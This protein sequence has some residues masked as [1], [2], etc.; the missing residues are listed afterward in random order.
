[1]LFC[2]RSLFCYASLCVH[3]SFG[4]ISP[5]CFTFFVF[6]VSFGCYH[7]MPLPH[8]AVGWSAVSDCGIS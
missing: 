6:L 7:S 4:I 2:V 8:G 3:S 1:M 5:G